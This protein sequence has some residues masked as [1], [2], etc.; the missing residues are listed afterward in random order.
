MP[1][2]FAR[3]SEFC[4]KF[5]TETAPQDAVDLIRVWF[6]TGDRRLGLWILTEDNSRAVAHLFATPEP[7]G[8]ESWKYTL[9]RQAEADCGIDTTRETKL[10]FEAVKAWTRSL[11]LDQIMMLT[12]RDERAMT[13]RWGFMPYKALMKLNL[14]KEQDNG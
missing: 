7:I 8:L 13:R 9:I 12:H 3:V 11:G 10:V 4:R 6:T 14:D 5:D 1:T 2:V